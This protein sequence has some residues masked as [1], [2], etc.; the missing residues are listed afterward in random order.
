M[1]KSGEDVPNR[2]VLMACEE[3]RAALI[4]VSELLDA[5]SEEGQP[6]LL[7]FVGETI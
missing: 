2:L 7:D 4:A 5:P 3:S 6:V 1:L